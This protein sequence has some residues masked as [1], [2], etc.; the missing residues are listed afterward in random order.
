MTESRIERAF[1]LL[2]GSGQKGFI[3]F[4]TAGDPNLES[5]LELLLMLAEEGATVIELGIPFSDPMAD[6]VVIQRASDRALRNFFHLEDVFRIVS[7]FR[8]RAE[9]P[10]IFF[11]YLNPIFQYGFERFC[12]EAKL[13]GADGILITD[14]I[15]EESDDFISVAR[16]SGLDVIFLAA[17]TSSDERLKMIAKRSSGFIYAVSR[18]GV[19]GMSKNLSQEVKDLVLRIKKLSSLPVAVGFGVS[20]RE[21]I[22]DIWQF[23]D[24]AVVGSAIVKRIEDIGSDSRLVEGVRDFVR[25]LLRNKR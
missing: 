23:A 9:T 19:T 2:R 11:S 7:N 18:T 6:G 17:P 24:A 4:I 22:E 15:P 1:N 10:L 8:R 16:K 3:P 14:L 12:K 25:G 20:N 5:T 21:Q 13:S